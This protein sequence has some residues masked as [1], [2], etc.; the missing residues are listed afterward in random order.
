MDEN[1]DVAAPPPS[2]PT[3]AAISMDEPRMSAPYFQRLAQISYQVYAD[4]LLLQQRPAGSPEALQALSSYEDC[5]MQC[6]H[7][8][9]DLV[10]AED[11]AEAA[12]EEARDDLLRLSMSAGILN[13]HSGE[14]K[15]PLSAFL[16]LAMMGCPALRARG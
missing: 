10:D 8:A 1:D 12:A 3:S 11:A 16:R 13:F 15:R 2:P 14:V 5:L 6:I 9:T 4:L 7:V